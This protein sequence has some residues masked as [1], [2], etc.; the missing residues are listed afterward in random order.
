M[1]RY[2][3]VLYWNG[4]LASDLSQTPFM[5]KDHQSNH[6]AGA[7]AGKT[8]GVS[9]LTPGLKVIQSVQSNSCTRCLSLSFSHTHTLFSPPLSVLA[10]SWVL[11]GPD[12]GPLYVWSSDLFSWY[13]RQKQVYFLLSRCSW[14]SVCSSVISV[15]SKGRQASSAQ[16]GTRTLLTRIKGRR[17]FRT[18]YVAPVF[19]FLG[20]WGGKVGKKEV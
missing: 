8:K 12:S 16:R 4:R 20:G 6:L 15:S 17:K 9:S 11:W 19:Y 13:L 14:Y 18:Q 2:S 7:V 10:S 5:L 1:I 3:S